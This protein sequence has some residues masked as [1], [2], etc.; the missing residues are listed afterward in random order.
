MSEWLEYTWRSIKKQKAR[1]FL[2]IVGVAI[3]VFLLTA[4]LF[5]LDAARARYLDY[6]TH[7]SG[8]QD[9]V[10]TCTG[11]GS[12]LPTRPEVE[13]PLSGFDVGQTITGSSSDTRG[14]TTTAFDYH[15]LVGALRATPAL[16]AVSTYLPRY[17]TR[18]RVNFSTALDVDFEVS[19]V[20][21]GD[22]VGINQSDPAE[23]AFGTLTPVREAPLP[24]FMTDFNAGTFPV[25]SCL[26]L[27]RTARALGY[28]PGDSIYLNLTVPLLSTANASETAAFR[29]YMLQFYWRTNL[30][31]PNY[32]VG[33]NL[34]VG[35]IV[36]HEYK[37]Q[38]GFSQGI[39]VNLGLLQAA[40]NQSGRTTKLVAV[41]ADPARVY[42]FSDVEQSRDRVLALATDIQRAVGFT[43]VIETPKLARLE[44]TQFLSYGFSILAWFV[45]AVSGLVAAILIHGILNTS[46]EERVREF[47]VL[48]VLGAHGGLPIQLV[49][50][51]S[52]LFYLLGTAVGMGLAYLAARFVIL[53]IIGQFVPDY[54]LGTNYTLVVSPESILFP[55][56]VG[57]G[58]STLV[59][60]GPALKVRK[61]KIVEAIHP[62]RHEEK[63]F[64]LEARGAV[65]WRVVTIG[66]ILATN[67][68]LLFILL[69]H[70]AVT[71]N[72]I[73]IVAYLVGLLLSFLLGLTLVAVGLIPPLQELCSRVVA[74]VSQRKGELIKMNIRRHRR[75]NF[76][77]SVT[78]CL[79]FAFIGF[80]SSA[81]Y[82]IDDELAN[83][84]ELSTGADI[85][86]EA[87]TWQGESH[88][89]T[90]EFAR[91]V[92]AI[93]GVERTCSVLARPYDMDYGTQRGMS[94][95]L[96]DFVSPVSTYVDLVSVEPTYA[97]VVYANYI[98]VLDRKLP[99]NFT[100]AQ[101]ARACS[102]EMGAENPFAPLYSGVDTCMIAESLSR[103]LEIGL[104]DFVRLNFRESVSDGEG[105]MV[106]ARFEVVGIIKA[107]PG[108]DS[109][110]S[111][112][113]QA[114]GGGVLVA[115][116]V[117]E[118]Y[119]GLTAPYLLDKVFVR[120]RDDLRTEEAIDRIVDRIDEQLG[121]RWQF[122]TRE[123]VE[124]EA[125]L[126]EGNRFLLN[127]INFLGIAFAMFGLLATSNSI[128]IER[129]KE[130]A[131]LRT[132]GLKGGGL[133]TMIF[134][135]S[136]VTM[137]ASVIAGS[138]AGYGCA[139]LLLTQVNLFL[140]VPNSY[141]Y[142]WRVI[143]TAW[144]MGA[145][146][147]FLGL[148]VLLRKVKRE[149]IMEV[150]RQTL[151]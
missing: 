10:L 133:F 86:V 46:V 139:V 54:L 22:V 122:Y 147:L 2:G 135:E 60:L 85:V 149:K 17:W 93:E 18:A 117:Y 72:L 44:E 66:V 51:E 59:A 118:R 57:T 49:F 71:L 35:A 126:T 105:E 108:F 114:Q 121:T 30:H 123:G 87:I 32:T 142:P 34:T 13:S 81:L 94:V 16:S 76:N 137:T 82:V 140:Q 116:E 151:V 38:S 42:D 20:P 3:S 100:P 58:I 23:R 52:L 99:A 68:G 70:L 12:P 104:G 88:R 120:V 132:L 56:L 73:G 98:Q 145:V 143:V 48:R 83:S 75:R 29:D 5:T 37:F 80:L 119:L 84:R 112:S 128:V 9:F 26:L 106:S 21:T 28:H 127:V 96:N 25:N 7:E 134:V 115:P 47:G 65:N 40:F 1:A 101:L 103:F 110:K 146:L 130:F 67:G 92:Q 4:M 43:Y 107:L 148:R 78:F 64:K 41:H 11:P 89:L 61:L 27:E 19:Y 77:A 31:A 109:F 62:Y 129:K 79:T 138:L 50:L 90:T 8:N 69:P 55:L 24:G 136:L 39:I 91:E 125:I 111:L 6:A 33:V 150:F 14:G 124:E 97:D 63:F 45:F 131:V 113:I 36:T 144:I 74:F 15:A 102:P 141:A 95:S 53:D